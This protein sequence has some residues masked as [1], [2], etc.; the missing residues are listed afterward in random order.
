MATITMLADA[1]EAKDPYT[2]GHCEHVASLAERVAERL[3][4]SEHDRSVVCHAALLHDVGKIGIADGILNKPGPLSPEE[5]E[6]VRAHVRVG[7][8]LIRNIPALAPIANAVLGHHERFD[9]TGY[10]QGLEGEEIPIAARIICV[11]DS[12]CAMT[13]KRSYK[14]A[15]GEEWAR[16][17]LERCTG[18]QFDPQVVEAF[19][20]VLDM[21][22]PLHDSDGP[23]G[24][25]LLPVFGYSSDQ[26]CVR[27]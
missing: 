24:Y 27:G 23:T 10:P 7:A 11:V 1:A 13:T 14:E 2:H 17:E 16:A 18:T 25:N 5:F 19:L 9:G 12:F 21:P 22:E 8:D 4:L 20:A 15:W 3:S 6:V 26:H